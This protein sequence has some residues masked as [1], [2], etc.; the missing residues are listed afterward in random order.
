[1]RQDY[2]DHEGDYG[3]NTFENQRNRWN[4]RK[5]FLESDNLVIIC[6]KFVFL[7]VYSSSYSVVAALSLFLFLL[8]LF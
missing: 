3:V 6:D 8:L 1:M 7:I 2:R 5:T 4:M